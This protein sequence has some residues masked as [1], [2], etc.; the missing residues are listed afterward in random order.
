M[1]SKKLYLHV[2]LIFFFITGGSDFLDT[3]S[4]FD[5][6]EIVF[7]TIELLSSESNNTYFS[8]IFF[9][10]IF[11]DF[12]ILNLFG[13]VYGV[14]YAGETEVGEHEILQVKKRKVIT[15]DERQAIYAALLEKSVNGKLK[16]KSTRIVAEKFSV[17]L[18]T[19]Q[20]IWKRTK[21]N[22]GDGM[23]SV[24]H[25]KTKNCGRKRIQ[26]DMERFRNLPLQ[27][28]TTVRAS[29][30]GMN[31]SPSLFYNNYKKYGK[32]RR[33]TNAIKPQLTDENKKARLQFCLS[34]LKEDSLPHDPT[35]NDMF[36]LIHIDEKWFNMSRKNETY[37]LLPD[38]EDPYRTCKSKNFVG[39]VMFL[40]AIARPRFDAEGKV[41]FSGKIG[42]FPFVTKEPAKRSSVNRAAGTLETKAMTSVTRDKVRSILINDVMPAI[43]KKWPRED[44]NLPIIIQQDNARTHIDPND[45]EFC[46]AVRKTGFDI[47]INCQP[48]NSPDLNVLDLGFFRAIQSLKYKDASKNIEELTAGVERAFESFSSKMFNRIF[49]TLQSCMECIMKV[50]GSNNYKIPHMRKGALERRGELSCQLKCDA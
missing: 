10:F 19:V 30:S 29:A 34:M 36:N 42:I 17:P 44:A 37:Y 39:K 24:L 31:I 8:F 9:I 25:R 35:F 4:M 41:T 15:N 43:I 40:A 47:R 46:E 1:N 49:L 28:R 18:R 6:D 11:L 26:I 3:G 5:D 32:I 13:I 33:H 21:E 16:K 23:T 12:D 50:R 27:Q 38:E 2:N 22:V 45:R 20:R 7:D 14:V 48:P